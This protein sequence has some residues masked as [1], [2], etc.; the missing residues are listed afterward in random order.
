MKILGYEIERKRV[1]NINVRIRQDG[2]VYISAPLN[3]HEKYIEDFL[4][5]K[6]DWIEKNVSTFKKFTNAKNNLELYTDTSFILYLG[7]IYT[8]RV[9]QSQKF[10]ININENVVEIH[11]DKVDKESIKNIVYTKI[12]YANAKI[13]FKK[14]MDYYLNLTN[15]GSIKELRLSVMKTKWGICTPAKRKIT[16]NIELMKKSLTEIDSVI[17]HE[18]AHLVHPN[19]SKDFYLYIDKY[20]KNYKEINKN[21][22]KIL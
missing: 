10:L 12:Y 18:I 22:N 19:H 17:I 14:R 4:I 21:L 5:K 20:F 16:L 15:N 8:L 11:T 13:L 7:K 1:K 2:S 6:R 9:F 3:L